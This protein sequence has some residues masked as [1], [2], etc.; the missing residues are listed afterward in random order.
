MRSRETRAQEKQENLDNWT[1]KHI[2]T[3]YCKAIYEG[4]K[5]PKVQGVPEET[6]NFRST[7]KSFVKRKPTVSKETGNWSNL[8]KRSQFHRESRKRD[9]LRL[10]KSLR[11]FDPG[12]GWTLAACLTHASRAEIIAEGGFGRIHG[13][14]SGGWVR[15]AWRTCPSQGDNSWKRLLIPHMLT[16]PHGAGR[17]AETVK[18][19]SASD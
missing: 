18:D 19:G 1:V 12:S 11:E 14:L 8:K 6:Y 17:K 9:L 3:I 15:N 16:A 2:L 4:S 5:N 13:Y 7:W 10:K